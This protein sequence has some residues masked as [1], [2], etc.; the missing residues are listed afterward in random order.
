MP[1]PTIFD[2]RPVNP[3]LTNLSIAGRNKKFLAEKLAPFASQPQQSGTFF[4]YTPSFW[5]RVPTGGVRASNAPYTKLGYGV[6]SDTYKTVE[7]GFEKL[8]PDPIRNASQTPEDL[9][10]M[11]VRFLTNSLQMEIEAAV[12]AK[13]FTSSVWGAGD[14]TLTGANQW[15]DYANSDP[16]KDV[17]AGRLAIKRLVGEFPNTMF[18]GVS[19]WEKLIEHPL[20]LDK[21]KYTQKGILTEDLLAAVF[22]VDEI[23]VGDTSYNSAAE[24]Q[25]QVGADIW[26]TNALL[27]CRNT[28]TLG[29]ANGAYTY[30]W[31]EVGNFPWAVQDY[32]DEGLRGIVTRVFTHYDIKVV[33][34][35]HG[36][37][38]NACTSS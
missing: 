2:V 24:G 37:M 23:V 13:L 25:T 20:L 22:K 19:S 15:D 27:L 35:S 38:I 31:D 11:D 5:M 8:L 29:V 6:S 16:V 18:I 30:I 28:P 1:Q 26:G 17:K 14:V 34:N 4:I 9:Q 10:M 32:R 12:A 21:F 36:Y 33:S 7:H 3:V